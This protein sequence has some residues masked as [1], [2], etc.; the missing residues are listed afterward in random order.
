[1]VLVDATLPGPV[2][3][4][5]AASVIGRRYS[6]PVIFLVD[7]AEELPARAWDAAPYGCALKKEGGSGL[8]L[9]SAANFVIGS[10]GRI[11]PLSD[12]IG[13][14]TTMRVMLRLSAVAPV[15]DDR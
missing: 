3:G 14:G 2:D 5:E 9:H 1:M 15:A 11:Q 6:L 13:H 4:A 8:G 12:G 7:G 10:G